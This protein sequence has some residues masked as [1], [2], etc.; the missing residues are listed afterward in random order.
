M[1]LNESQQLESGNNSSRT[2]RL[3]SLNLSYIGYRAC[4]IV[5]HDA[6]ITK[7]I[8]PI[9]QQESL[10]NAKVNARQQCMYEGPIAKK[11]TANQRTEHIM[12]KSTFSG[13][14]RCRW[15]HG[16]VYLHSFSSCQLLPP[17]SAKYQE[18][19]NLFKV[20]NLGDN[21]KRICNFLY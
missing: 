3:T 12:L 5:A 1:T 8:R 20:I 11:S 18:N 13:L 15:L 10:V 7:S 14:Q 9:Y 19:S 16:W 4:I 2:L 17:K 6:H 21:R